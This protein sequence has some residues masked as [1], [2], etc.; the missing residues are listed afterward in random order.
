MIHDLVSAEYKGGYKIELSFDDGSKGTVDFSEYLNKG[1]ESDRFRDLNYFKRFKVDHELG[2]LTWEGAWISR[3][4]HCT[5]RPQAAH[6]R[7]G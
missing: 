4:R 1:G 6:F 7:L 2:V 3:Q 5:P